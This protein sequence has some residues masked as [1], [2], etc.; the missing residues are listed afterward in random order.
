[1]ICKSC[2]PIVKAFCLDYST[3]WHINRSLD[4]TGFK[5]YLYKA[6]EFVLYVK[7]FG[8]SEATEIYFFLSTKKLPKCKSAIDYNVSKRQSIK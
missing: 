8:F 3:L 5:G 1:M 2:S 6:S 7:L 4:V